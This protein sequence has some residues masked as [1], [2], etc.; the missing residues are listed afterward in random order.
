[1]RCTPFF[2]PQLGIDQA[3]ENLA[4]CRVSSIHDGETRLME[5]DIR[6][7]RVEAEEQ[8]KWSMA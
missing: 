1:M 3:R 5:D 7:R 6:K 2:T 4:G 8:A